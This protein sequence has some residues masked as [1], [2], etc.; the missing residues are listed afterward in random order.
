LQR[1]SGVYD[2]PAVVVGVIRAG[3]L[4]DSRA[5]GLSNVELAVPAST[6]HVFEIGSISKQFT[7]YL[8]LMLFEK[9]KV[10]LDAPVGKYLPDLPAPWARPTLHQLLGHISGLPDFE[11]AF[12]YGVYRQTL[13]DSEFQTR[14]LSLPIA[15]EPGEKW[16]YSNTNY[17]L[18]ARVIETVSGQTYN[19]F[20]R[21]R[22]FSP[23]SMNSSSTA[24]PTVVLRGR[25]A[26]YQLVENR[27]EN[28][29]PM[30]PSTGRGLGDIVT[31]VQDIASWERELRTP[32]LL[33]PETARRAY[34]PVKLNNGTVTDY[35]YGWFT[36]PV[37]G[38]PALHHNGGTA[39]FVADY[40]RFPGRDLSIIVF[41]NRFNAPASAASV[42]RLVEPGLGGP[43]PAAV[44]SFDPAQ[45]AR[46]R[47]MASSASRASTE[48][49]EDWFGAD[50]WRSTKPYLRDIEWNY[51][52]RGPLRAVTAVGRNGTQ[53]AMKPTYRVVFEKM[54]RLMTFEFDGSG[55]I[56][57]VEA[58]DE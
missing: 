6:Q 13:A 11:E 49:H 33:K 26:G 48:W 50:F 46:V 7:A 22:I 32:Q 17:W 42:A 30:Q 4:A 24:L 51:T 2:I 9:A 36:S 20:V 5:V 12:G 52:R 40:L 21:E 28:R 8:I 27:L 38:S 25:A 31:T 1:H 3:R 34:E 18:L 57:S 55:K 19:Q 43:P 16:A 44:A 23:L 54:T 45:V 56:V 15:S 14:L 39:G 58:E 47:Q 35:G 37:L 29:E 53:D 10:D 41:A